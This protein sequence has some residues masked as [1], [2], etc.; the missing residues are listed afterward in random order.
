MFAKMQTVFNFVEKAKLVT[1]SK[2][3]VFQTTIRGPFK[4]S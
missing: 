4:K 1:L 2:W 3:L